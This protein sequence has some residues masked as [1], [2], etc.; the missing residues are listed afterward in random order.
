MTELIKKN[1][2]FLYIK[3]H[4]YTYVTGLVTRQIP[5]DKYN[6]MI[7]LSDVS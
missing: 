3:V 5:F 7:S 6:P 1:L 2:I 4:L